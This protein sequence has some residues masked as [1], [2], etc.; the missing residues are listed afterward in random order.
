[1]PLHFGQKA[2]ANGLISLKSKRSPRCLE[3]IV[4]QRARPSPG[5]KK[6]TRDSLSSQVPALR[7]KQGPGQA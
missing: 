3:E 7:L 5:R 4:T 1:M 6:K 2:F